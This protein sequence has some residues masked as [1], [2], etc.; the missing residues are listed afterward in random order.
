M[1]LQRFTVV[2]VLSCFCGCT[3]SDADKGIT[4]PDVISPPP[5]AADFKSASSPAVDQA[6]PVYHGDRAVPTEPV[7][8]QDSPRNVRTQSSRVSK[9]IAIP[10]E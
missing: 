2:I 1:K 7:K 6:E 8:Q 3:G 10:D 9:T 4:K 5:T